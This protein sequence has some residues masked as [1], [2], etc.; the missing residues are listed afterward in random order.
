MKG[1]AETYPAIMNTMRD[2]PI[3]LLSTSTARGIPETGVE[4]DAILILACKLWR[5][6]KVPSRRGRW[7]Y[8][9]FRVFELGGNGVDKSAVATVE[10]SRPIHA[11]DFAAVMSGCSG[12]FSLLVDG[13]CMS[14]TNK[15]TFQGSLLIITS[16]YS[17]FM[18]MSIDELCSSQALFVLE[19]WGNQLH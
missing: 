15:I 3:L 8:K 14:L 16:M 4:F 11:R 18:Q 19:A 12:R 10:I 9:A 5:I 17:L 6:H 13:Q 2:L 1:K 7:S